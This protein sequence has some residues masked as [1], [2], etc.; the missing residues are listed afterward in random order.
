MDAVTVG[1]DIGSSAIRAAEVAVGKDGRRK[2]RAF[3]QIGLPPGDV[4]DGEI[5]NVEGVANALKRLWAD[6][7]FSTT[8]VVLGVSGPRVFVRR[9][10]VPALNAEEIRSSLRFDS[11]ELVPIQMEDASFDFSLLG[12]PQKHGDN[13]HTQ[14]ILLVAAHI[15]LL[16]RYVDTLKQAGLNPTVMDAAPLALMRAVPAVGL[17]N[18]GAGLEVIVSIGAELTTVA[19][20]E[21][22]VP[23][24]IRSLTVGGA[25]MT[26]SLAST[27][28]VAPDVAERLKRGAVPPGDPVEADVS[29]ALS[30]DLRDLA[31]D[32]RATIDFFLSQAS[33]DRIERLLV[34]G[35]AA[36]TTGLAHA[37]AG[38]LDAPIMVVDPL[39]GLDT[40][41]LA[42]TEEDLARISAAA[43]TSI[44]LARWATDAPL[45][46]LSLLPHEVIAARKAR[47]V[48]VLA[49]GCVAGLAA[50]LVI[51][52]G[53]E[54]LAVH[55]AQSK[56]V[57]AEGQ[58]ATMQSQVTR[59]QATTAVHG[60]MTARAAMVQSDLS[61]D[62]D[63][64][65][66]LG[67]LAT[68][69]PS[70]LQL[71]NFSGSTM[72]SANSTAGTVATGFG[73]LSFGVQGSGGLPA[74]AAWIDG[75]ALDPDI[76]SLTLGGITVTSNG[77]TVNFS[78]TGQLT[79]TSY[80]NR[81]QE[82]KP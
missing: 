39:A 60:Q 16:R 46:R 53:A 41:G 18:S 80:S 78:S 38:D 45:I 36:Q 9:A 72:A 28:K 68:V 58:V 4:V 64:V 33:Y 48:L 6:G 71:Q 47:R 75:L 70:S 22:G 25:K 1:L 69:M 35:G 11:Q 42:F 61:G 19:V 63:W 29:R 55:H 13:K 17:E 24:F 23:L 59:L 37:I 49:G 8:D 76:T 32:I 20:R 82:Y 3:A 66:V 12:S 14:C 5:V 57:S 43:T 73:S 74:A 7:H 27:L 31:E 77:G 21:D 2:L 30:P 67:Q 51:A 62:V 52:G 65:R 15:E 79:T 40:S 26:S 50:V 56:L 81:A 34:T 10:D 44:G 54:V